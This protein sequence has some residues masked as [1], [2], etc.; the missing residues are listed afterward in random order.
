MSL[1]LVFDSQFSKK[2]S[3]NQ[4]TLARLGLMKCL[5]LHIRP[6]FAPRHRLPASSGPRLGLAR[7][8]TPA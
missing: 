1:R 4:G 7:K 8:N 3:P 2:K 5:P 6:S